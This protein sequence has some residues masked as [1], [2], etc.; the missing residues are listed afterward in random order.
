MAYDP[1]EP[2]DER[3]K[4]TSSLGGAMHMAPGFP[5][6]SLT[7]PAN[8][9]K[10]K[11]LA[12]KAEE[13]SRALDFKPTKMIVTDIPHKFTIN[14]QEY[15]E[16]G[17]YDPQSEYITLRHAL[18]H[19]TGDGVIAHEIAHA[20]FDALMKDYRAERDAMEKDPDYRKENTS[21]WVPYDESNPAHVASK[22]L[23]N[24][25]TTDGQ[26][27]ERKPG[28]MNPDGSLNEPYASRYPLYQ[29][30]NEVAGGT[31]KGTEISDFAKTDG[32]SKY[33]KDYWEAWQNR[34]VGTDSA[35]HETLAE[36]ARVKWEVARDTK[37][38]K[39]NVK[40]IKKNGGQW[41]PDDEKQ[42]KQGMQSRTRTAT[43]NYHL[44]KG[45]VNGRKTYFAT[46]KKVSRKNWEDLYDL[47]DSNWTRR[48]KK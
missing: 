38:H 20:K 36:M 8:A 46:T 22:A 15:N 31:R 48:N 26:I 34:E 33:S 42:W 25:V 1:N 37:A 29:R 30:Y 9:G 18:S 10:A 45:D 23:G 21:K 16:G 24:I 14:G 43:Q 5:A 3:G 39:D 12:E 6:V 32:V 2:R 19:E 27:R 40:Y 35:M 41:T 17:H 4:W 47:M 11:L 7:D 13:V 44:G 28:F